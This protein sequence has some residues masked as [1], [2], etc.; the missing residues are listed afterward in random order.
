MIGSYFITGLPRSRTAWLSNLLTWGP[1]FCWH[2]GSRIF[3]GAQGLARA[4]NE[5][6]YTYAGTADSGLIYHWDYL[7]RVMPFAKWVVIRRDPIEVRDSLKRM[8]VPSFFEIN[9]EDA[10]VANY[11]ALGKLLHSPI[12]ERSELAVWDYEDLDDE[13]A[14]RDLV[15]YCAPG[16]NWSRD[17]WEMLKDL[18][19]QVYEKKYMEAL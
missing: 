17:R 1:S 6:D 18:Q 14:V 11:E 15:S 7:T 3:R 9:E 19:V 8:A 2:E 5:T 16:F 13:E 4:L 12:R 10:V